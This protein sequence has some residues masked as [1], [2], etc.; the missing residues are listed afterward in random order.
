MLAPFM[1]VSL[2]QSF[3]PSRFVLAS[4]EHSGF[5]GPMG[6]RAS[7][8]RMD[9]LMNGRAGRGDRFSLG[10]L[11]SEQTLNYLRFDRGCFHAAEAP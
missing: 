11:K 9:G 8:E 1:H 6:W 4:R 7:C 3:V 10:E 5:G 2:L